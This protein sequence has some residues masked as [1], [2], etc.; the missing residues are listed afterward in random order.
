MQVRR[1]YLT[2][3]AAYL[4]TTVE[5]PYSLRA[6][7]P[8]FYAE[9]EG[10]TN[11]KGKGKS[12]KLICTLCNSAYPTEPHADNAV[13]WQPWVYKN[14]LPLYAGANAGGICVICA[15][16]LMLRQL[17]QKG[18]LRLTGSKFEA[19]KTKY[20]AI[21]PDYFFTAET[22]AMVEGI[23]DKL[24]DVNFFTLRQELTGKTLRVSDVLA[25]HLFAF[26][27]PPKSTSIRS[28]ADIDE[29]DDD[30]A[31]EESEEG[32]EATDEAEGSAKAKQPTER[33]YIK[34]EFPGH[35]YPG[36]G[37]FG[38]RA[39]KDDSSDTA[40]WAMP[41]LLSLAL[42]LV[43]GAKVVA[44]EMLLPLFS[45][46]H[47]FRETVVFDAPHPFLGRLLDDTRSGWLRAANEAQL[48]DPGL[49]GEHGNVCQEWETGMATP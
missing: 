49:P 23:L 29:A 28:L 19:L 30:V 22:G 1:R 43:T 10:Y 4:E 27:G 12:K 24:Q 40:S 44:S 3:L 25:S 14:K 16:E 48:A 17:L 33:S 32:D 7:A 8:D 9:I 42:P 39:S 6:G 41:A 5:L 46:G 26:D 36:M 47:D 11:A 34:Y 13:L 45:S 21:Y 31:D 20:I 37:F 15:L 18:Q 2:H 35:T 38:M